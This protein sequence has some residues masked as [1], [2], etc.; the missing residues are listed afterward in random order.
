MGALRGS[1]PPATTVISR[2]AHVGVSS[3]LGHVELALS[4][5]GN[6]RWHHHW[7]NPPANHPSRFTH[8]TG[9]FCR[10]VRQAGRTPSGHF[11]VKGQL[12]VAIRDR[13][14]TN[15]WGPYLELC[16]TVFY[17]LALLEKRR[18][19]TFQRGRDLQNRSPR[20]LHMILWSVSMTPRVVSPPLGYCRLGG[21]NF[22]VMM[23][24]LHHTS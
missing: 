22:T 16:E 11:S 18:S 24:H 17:D 15:S 20:V 12:T 6:G 21:T 2:M 10:S 19:D 1:V 8:G 9:A 7:S 5:L 23:G 4:V 3:E 13:L 14:N